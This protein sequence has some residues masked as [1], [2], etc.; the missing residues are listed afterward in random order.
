MNRH[1]LY[2]VILLVVG[3]Q[4]C[5]VKKFIPEGEQLYTGGE[6][7]MEANFRIPD[8]KDIESELNALLKPEPNSKILGMRIGL[9]AH[10]KGSQEK[11]GFINRFLKN[12][13]GEEPVYFSEVNPDRT[14]ELIFNRLENRGFFYS[15]VE[16]EVTR[17]KHFASVRY[18]ATLEEPYVLEKYSV[19]GDSLQIERKMAELLE[20]TEL[21]PGMRFDLN[22]LKDERLRLEEALKLEGYYNITPD[23]LIFEADT[24]NYEE[25]KFD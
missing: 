1:L 23:F 18:T 11:P 4:S 12:K 3:I 5:S 14:E 25:R 16:S 8:K 13:L 10:Y 2:L 19:D 24:N 7:D 20:E 21:K 17:K 9:W 6:V 15:L 22:L